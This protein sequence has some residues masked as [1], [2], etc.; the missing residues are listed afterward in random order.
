MGRTYWRYWQ[1]K[2]VCL[3]NCLMRNPETQINDDGVWWTGLWIV[4]LDVYAQ[5]FQIMIHGLFNWVC[6]KIVYPY[7]Q[8][9]MIII[10][11]KWLFHCGYTPFLDKPNSSMLM[12]F[13]LSRTYIPAVCQT[14]A[15]ICGSRL[16]HVWHCDLLR[17]SPMVPLL[18]R[19]FFF[20]VVDNHQLNPMES[21]RAFPEIAVSLMISCGIIYIVTT[22]ILYYPKNVSGKCHSDPT[23]EL[24]QPQFE[25]T[26]I[27]LSRHC[28]VFGDVEIWKTQDHSVGSTRE[29]TGNSRFTG[30]GRGLWFTR[31]SISWTSL[32]Q[33]WDDQQESKKTHVQTFAVD[34]DVLYWFGM[35][36]HGTAFL[37]ASLLLSRRCAGNLSKIK[38]TIIRFA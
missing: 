36:F 19:L 33:F 7:T 6:L 8:W 27:M 5:T 18:Q 12:Q 16:D 34:S 13:L 30:P 24:L 14:Q 17:S 11:T 26:R 25:M 10:P 9:L 15:G 4:Q 28:S 3:L 22:Y 1:V 29:S 32:N 23:F 2:L 21:I 31:W 38:G 20:N 35:E 37:L